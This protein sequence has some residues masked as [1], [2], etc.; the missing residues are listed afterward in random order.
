MSPPAGRTG[1]GEELGVYDDLLLCVHPEEWVEY[2]VVEF[3]YADLSGRGYGELVRR[4]GHRS[5]QTATYSA[6]A[7]LGRALSQLHQ[8][9]LL[10]SRWLPATGYWSYNGEISGGQS[11]E[12]SSLILSSRGPPSPTPRC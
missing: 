7:F 3:R 11:L 4:Y 8:E 2:G 9:G 1:V 5:I 10:L 12:R 6:S